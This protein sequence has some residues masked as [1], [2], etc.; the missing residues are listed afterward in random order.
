[1]Y[2]FHKPILPPIQTPPAVSSC[3][4]VIF[5]GYLFIFGG[6]LENGTLSNELWV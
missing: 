3:G 2:F 1:M 6:Y 4:S 5:N